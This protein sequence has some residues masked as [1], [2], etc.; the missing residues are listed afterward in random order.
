[1]YAAVV[2]SPLEEQGYTNIQFELG[3]SRTVDFQELASSNIGFDKL[4]LGDMNI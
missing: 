2:Y 3:K 4:S 1:M